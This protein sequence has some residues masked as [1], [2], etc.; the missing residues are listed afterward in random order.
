VP[1]KAAVVA[2]LVLYATDIGGGAADVTYSY[3]HL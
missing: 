1:T 3:Q 2:Y